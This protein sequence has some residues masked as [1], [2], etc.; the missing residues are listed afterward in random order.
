MDIHF[1]YFLVCSSY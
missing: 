1:C